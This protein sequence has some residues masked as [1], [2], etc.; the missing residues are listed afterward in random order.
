MTK[1]ISFANQKGG[2]GK[3]T[4]CLQSAFYLVEAG[5]RVLVID[6]DP[7]GNTS[8]RLAQDESGNEIEFS[9][10]TTA[11]LFRYGLGEIPVMSCPRGMDLIW[12]TKNDP[13]LSEIES[14][15]LECALLP[16]ENLKASRLLDCYDYVLI[17]CPPSLGRKLIAALVLSTHVLCPVQV[18]G[19]AVDGVEGLLNTIISVQSEL[20]PQLENTGI[21]INNLNRNFQT[22]MEARQQ[23]IDAVPDLIYATEIG[24]RGKLDEATNKGIPVWCIKTSSGRAAAKDVRA[25][26]EELIEKVG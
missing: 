10:T 21:V 5:H 7:Q 6:L 8:S 9:G 14:L 18:S 11:D 4:I 22:H 24:V 23:L 3:S 1:I 17:D 26:I 20:N 15:D 16:S 12:T 2:V 19:F 13:V 25:V